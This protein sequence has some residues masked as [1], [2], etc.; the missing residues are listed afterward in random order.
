MFGLGAIEIAIIAALIIVFFGGKKIPE[1]FR[2]I[3]GAIREFK[4]GAK[5]E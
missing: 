3:S 5:D 1:L 2:G 4:K